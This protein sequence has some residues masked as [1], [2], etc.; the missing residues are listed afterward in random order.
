MLRKAEEALIQ[1]RTREEHPVTITNVRFRA[2]RL[3]LDLERYLLLKYCRKS[4]QADRAA[5]DLDKVFADLVKLHDELECERKDWLRENVK[6]RVVT[7]AFMIAALMDTDGSL[8]KQVN[9]FCTEHCVSLKSSAEPGSIPMTRLT[10]AV[11]DYAMARFGVC[12][13]SEISDMYLRV[14]EL[15]RAI[16]ETE[17]AVLLT[18]YDRHRFALL[19]RCTLS[20]LSSR[21]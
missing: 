6:R 12:N 21:R 8:P 20:A 4:A 2:E 13:D 17:H 15:Q 19:I 11:A 7:N 10:S 1:D 5:R 18:R 3:A 16:K 9:K 14:A